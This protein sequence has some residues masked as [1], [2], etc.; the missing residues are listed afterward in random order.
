MERQSMVGLMLAIVTATLLGCDSASDVGSNDNSKANPPIAWAKALNHSF[1]GDGGDI[2]LTV[3]AGADVVLTGVDSFGPTVPVTRFDWNVSQPPATGPVALLW[4]NQ[5]TVSFRAPRDS[6]QL[7]L[8]V[9]DSNGVTDEAL[10]DVTVVD[11][12]D[13]NAFLAYGG[14]STYTIAAV[15]RNAVPLQNNVPFFIEVERSITYYDLLAPF[16]PETGAPTGT[17]RVEVIGSDSLEGEWVAEYGTGGV[18][19]DPA[20]VRSD[21]CGGFEN[22][23]FTLEMPT[24]NA[25]DVLAKIGKDN[26]DRAVNPALIDYASVD[27]RITL[28]AS[29]AGSL[30]PEAGI[31]VP[32]IV[33]PATAVNAALPRLKTSFTPGDDGVSVVMPPIGLDELLGP[34]TQVQDTRESAEAYYR[35]IDPDAT[36]FARKQT[37]SG[38]L[39]ATGFTTGATDWASVL[40]G[41]SAH[42][43]YLNNFDLGFGRDMYMRIGTCDDGDA[44]RLGDPAPLPR[45]RIGQCDIYGVVVNYASLEAAAKKIGPILAVAMEYTRVDPDGDGELIGDGPRITKFYTYAPDRKGDFRRVLSANLD[46][47]G[48][49][50]MPGVC[51]V[52]H[53]GTPGGVDADTN[54]DG[55]KV[56]ANGGDLNSGFL[57]WDLDAFK[58]SDDRSFSNASDPFFPE[59]ER[60]LA[61]DYTREAQSTQFKALNQL[62]YLTFDDGQTGNTSCETTDRPR[63][64]LARQL[65][66]GWYGGEGTPGSSF[67]GGFVPETWSSSETTKEM[68]RDVFAQNCRACHVLQ[69]P[70]TTEVPNQLAIGSYTEFVKARGLAPIMESGRM[71]FAR[72]TMDRFWIPDDAGSGDLL[73]QHLTNDGDPTTNSFDKP[74]PGAVIDD[75]LADGEQLELDDVV[76]LVATGLDPTGTFA[77]NLEKPQD[78]EAVLNFRSTANPVLSGIDEKGEYRVTLNVAGSTPVSCATAESD[79]SK[80]TTCLRWSREDS[81]PVVVSIEGQPLPLPAA[82]SFN[83]GETKELKIGLQP[84]GDGTPS[85]SGPFVVTYP[86]EF[87]T[88]VEPS[89]CSTPEVGLCLRVKTDGNVV[90]PVSISF[91]VRDSEGDPEETVV[92]TFAVVVPPNLTVVQ[93]CSLIV[94]NLPRGASGLPQPINLGECVGGVPERTTLNFR[95]L[96]GDGIVTDPANGLWT[97]LPP[98]GKMTL[99]RVN[100]NSTRISNDH[101]M[102]EFEAYLLENEQGTKV[103]GSASVLFEGTKV[104]VSEMGVPEVVR[105]G[106]AIDF[107][108]LRNALSSNEC[109]ECHQSSSLSR[110]PSIRWL[111]DTEF[112]G[113]KR[114]RCWSDVN[115]TATDPNYDEEGTSYVNTGTPIQSALIRKANGDLG[116]GGGNL[117]TPPIDSYPEW[118][119]K[120]VLQWI[121]QGA[122]YASAAA[123]P[124]DQ[125]CSQSD[126]EHPRP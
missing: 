124:P 110:P 53:G 118:L 20:G 39:R 105:Q 33:P 95:Y 79:D 35:T 84:A 126:T 98:L 54:G 56:Y 115:Q 17:P 60:S 51:T 109:G 96:S 36:V 31:C 38:W 32:D 18:G 40:S 80:S 89:D 75:G 91:T 117:I 45:S 47:R 67:N 3:R 113:Q 82:I 19:E 12:P 68:Y 66:E 1:A 97:Y 81:S 119:Q 61:A 50:F 112:D 44:P 49:K 23:R 6:L 72:M 24:L 114:M 62:A 21:G 125:M 10:V 34:P 120:A 30:P 57:S 106:D 83:A 123:S 14:P 5:S 101:S 28:R 46:G 122:Y 26:P 37:F 111:G 76:A 65:V 13:P 70:G 100:G 7:K 116:H 87:S 11:V 22:P 9:T 74:G 42:A 92:T 99:Y 15:T 25:D 78:S 102:I 121:Q 77:W 64:C 94:Q 71:P 4:R 59:S 90:A 27:V 43:V 16:D 86:D 29:G 93:N 104:S 48:E 107:S 103:S 63:F 8:T 41:S 52:C 85:F 108:E 55:Q 69:V 88:G 2:Q 73:A 58:Y